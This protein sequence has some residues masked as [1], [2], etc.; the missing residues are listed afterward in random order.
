MSAGSEDDWPLPEYNPG[1]R[2]NLHALGV[3]VLQFAQYE[4]AVHDL[5]ALKAQQNRLPPD[6]WNTFYLRLN[7]ETR[8]AAT[9]ALFQHEEVEA[10]R[11]QAENLLE[12]FVR[13]KAYRDHLVHA[14]LYGAAF[15]GDP[16]VLY[17]IKSSN[18]RERKAS[19]T[20]FSLVRLR[21]IANSIRQ[22]IVQAADLR[23][24]IRFQ[25]QDPKKV[26]KQY[27]KYVF[28]PAPGPLTMPKPLR[29][30]DAP[31]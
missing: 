20:K 19:Y 31:D 27:R 8:V 28:S 25:R 23:L 17:L 11:E 21:S 18:R 2:A 26:P 22:G 10:I 16:D 24:R 12:H 14:E 1:Q 4:R 15:G 29:T 13:C 5:F 9:K 3:I 7:G 6:F 30:R